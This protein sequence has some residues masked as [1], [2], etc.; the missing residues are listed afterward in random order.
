[1]PSEWVMKDLDATLQAA[2][3][4]QSVR[5]EGAR[6]DIYFV[7]DIRAIIAQVRT[8]SSSILIKV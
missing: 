8:I 7:N 5:Y 4:I 1:M 3:G 6:K 2:I